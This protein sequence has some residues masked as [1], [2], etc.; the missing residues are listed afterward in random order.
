MDL[1]DFFGSSDLVAGGWLW[2]G[3]PSSSSASQHQA[4]VESIGHLLSAEGGGFGFP[5][6]QLPKVGSL[7]RLM[8]PF[9]SKDSHLIETEAFC[10]TF[11]IF[12]LVG[13]GSDHFF[14]GPLLINQHERHVQVL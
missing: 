4:I 3:R 12:F 1:S 8:G 2:L 13:A 5:P 6:M 11:S 9:I 14:L 10:F 7:L